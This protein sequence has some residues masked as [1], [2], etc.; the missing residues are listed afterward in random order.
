MK[1]KEIRFLALFN[2][3]VQ[4]LV[5]RWQ[6]RYRW[7]EAEI[8]RLLDDMLAIADADNQV[9]PHYGGTMITVL[10][11]SGVVKVHRV[12]DGQQRLTTVSLLLTRIAE[13]LGSDG[14]CGELTRDGIRLDL[15]TNPKRQEDRRRKLRLQDGDEEEYRRIIDLDSPGSGDGAVSEAWRIVERTVDPGNVEPLIRGLHRLRVITI[16]LEDRDD[17]QQIFESLNATGQPLTEGE[18]VKNW[19]LM[20]LTEEVQDE[21]HDEHWLAVE[22]ALD[23]RHDA[24]LIDI[25]LRDV[26]RWR[27]GRR[28]A[29]DS[30]YDEFRRWAIRKGRDHPRRR[31]ELCSELA[32]LAALYGQL[33]G[34]ATDQPSRMVKRELRHLRWMGIHV[35]RPFTLRLLWDA[36]RRKELGREEGSLL[37]TLAA[38][39]SW[40]TRAWLADRSLAGLDKAFAELAHTRMPAGESD[41]TQFWIERIA[42]IRDE[43]IAVP[44]DAELREGIRLTSKYGGLNTRA[45]TAVLYAMIHREQRGEAPLRKSLS[46]EHIMPQKLNEGWRRDLGERA[47]EIH[48]QHAHRLG[49]LTLCGDRWNPALSNHPFEKKREIYRE[50]SIR[51]TR[52]L[53]ELPAW[54]EAAIKRRADELAHEALRLW[55]WTGVS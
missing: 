18:K 22:R 28:V 12:V 36:Q 40:I 32:G 34:T 55:P 43:R 8:R 38:V 54:D 31:P 53:A 30:T 4:Y 52:R 3:K 7:G 39:S 48:E 29:K 37:A 9:R 35:H 47:N 2:G 33:T 23:A 44:S 6:R 16:G 5:P 1:A 11:S 24:D 17:A 14:K 13:V 50:S 26:M 10:E 51:M 20:G 25:F 15:L 42:E 19:L 45:T 46:V 49:N 27:T 41:P 21:L